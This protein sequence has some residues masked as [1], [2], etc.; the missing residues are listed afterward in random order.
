[1]GLVLFLLI[2]AQT[3]L[4]LVLGWCLR[5][6][7]L[8]RGLLQ[9]SNETLHYILEVAI[10]GF[11]QVDA[12]GNLVDVNPAYCQLSGYTREELL[13]MHVSDL[14]VMQDP[15]EVV[16]RMQRLLPS[17]SAQFES[18]HR[19]KD[20][21]LWQVEVSVM[22]RSVGKV[23]FFAFLRDVTGRK[24]VEQALRASEDRMRGIFENIPV[25]I[26][27]STRAGKFVYTNPALG[28]ILGY[29]SAQDL[30]ATVNRTSI[31]EA[32]YVDPTRRDAILEGLAND[33]RWQTAECR[34]R[35]KDGR[36]IDAVLTMGERQDSITGESLLYGII[37]DISERKQDEYAI[38][39][40]NADLEQRVVERTLELGVAKDAAE[41][42]NRA[43]SAFLANMSHELRTPMN[44]IL[45]F[46]QLLQ[47][48][49]SLREDSRRKVATINR[50]GQ[51]LLAL[52]ND[53]L[54]ISR[55]ESGRSSVKIAA[56]DLGDML[57][58][59]EDLMR[60]RVEAK[61]LAFAV[62][63]CDPLP[64]WVLGDVHHLKQILINLIANA[65]KYT[66]KGHINLHVK[67]DCT[68]DGHIVF[69]VEDTGPGIAASD[70]ERVF[71][72]FYQTELGMLKGD[73]TGLGLSISRQYARLMDG[74]LSVASQ[75]GQGCVFT[76]RLPLP[77]TAAPESA[78]G[79]V[80]RA[81]I[82]ALELGVQDTVPRLLV[83][84]DKADNREL[85]YE[86]LTRVGFLVQ[87]VEDGLQAL[88]AFATW[89]PQLILMDMLMPVMDGY[90]AT[91][92]IRTLPGGADV[93]IVA[94]TANAFEEDR[95]AILAAGC[96]EML[97]KPVLETDL[98]KLLG[99]LLGIHYR[100]GVLRPTA[101]EKIAAEAS[102]T[103][104][105]DLP[106]PLLV[107]LQRAAECLDVEAVRAI[108]ARIAPKHAQTSHSLEALVDNFRFD[109]IVEWC[110]MANKR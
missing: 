11:W 45:G 54:E 31:A 5:R 93:R 88:A 52:I 22:C 98:Y 1:M 55:I 53:V 36:I 78:T 7:R 103:D 4:I 63:R 108:A 96:D 30:M 26:F 64:S 46:A 41:A 23:R 50:A 12:Q 81:P 91:R 90:E 27:A 57:H 6:H 71:Q 21:S 60:L 48:D 37:T 89:R 65:A 106:A 84:D 70:Q 107:E 73:G 58:E 33:K 40:L 28:Q 56:F 14:G 86:M 35:R 43:K 101:L 17:G 18:V 8:A 74:E 80:Q 62:K 59:L 25:G 2:V 32:M 34:Y 47:H 94:L 3:A 76:L 15:D 66:E 102:S 109:R 29:D 72:A 39:K 24:H 75:M 82:I 104:L 16:A 99:T 95:A 9:E 44:A 79:S 68:G 19:R 61:W 97:K 51:H 100:H 10:D 77:G 67:P 49:D 87:A 105:S 20:G 110:E 38:K 85:V 83:V 42:A 92:K 13:G 69:A